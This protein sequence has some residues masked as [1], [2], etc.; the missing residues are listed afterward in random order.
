MLVSEY[1]TKRALIELTT[2]L[3]IYDYLLTL[4]AEVE[5]MWG[6]KSSFSTFFFFANRY[7]NLL[8]QSI[9]V[10]VGD[11]NLSVPI[12]VRFLLVARNVFLLLTA[13]M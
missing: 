8:I 1:K 11:F 9:L 10:I 2:S 7:F 5:L 6:R 4:P 3:Q 12:L 13:C